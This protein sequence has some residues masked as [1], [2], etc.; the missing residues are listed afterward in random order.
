MLKKQTTKKGV[1]VTFEL[2]KPEAEVVEIV[3]AWNGWTPETMK[4]FKNGKHKLALDLPEGEHQ[5]R[6]L[7]D[8]ASWE[9]EPEADTLIANGHGSQNSVIRC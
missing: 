9:N 5:F 6:Y 8:R 1:K 7:I 3:G 4:K 2:D